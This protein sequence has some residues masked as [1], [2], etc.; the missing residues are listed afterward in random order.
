DPE[1]VTELFDAG[2]MAIEIP[3]AYGGAGRGLF[4]VVLAIEEIARVDPAVAVFVDVQ[5]ALVNSA[6]LR[7][8]SGDLKR[9]YLLRMAAGTVG[10]Y[11]I[12]EEE[13]GSDAFAMATVAQRD[14]QHHVL[15]GRKKWTTN[16]AE[17]GAFLVFARQ[18]DAT[19]DAGRITAFLVDRDTPGLGIGTRVDKLG[20]RASST[21][22]L[23]LDHVRV[24]AANV[25]GQSGL[26]ELLAVDTLTIGKIGI[27]AQ[28]VGLASGAL[29]AAVS[30]AQRRH[31]FGQPI[32]NFQGVQFP[33]AA[34]AAELSAARALL[35]DTVRLVD[36]GP[37]SRDLVT[38]AA[39]TKH[40]AAEVAE[41]TAAHA[42]ETLGGNGFTRD[43]PV[44]KFYRDA[45]VGKIYEGTTN[46][47]F[48][49]IAAALLR[50][51]DAGPREVGA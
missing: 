51:G 8:G 49:T 15:S 26:G 36:D 35:Y 20:I 45:K 3:E 4:D 24:P 21:C 22:D 25:I 40:I 43:H 14:G 18:Q 23:I 1:L 48:R 28:L 37:P 12:S 47:Q 2:L 42:V 16:A 9:R 33:L 6:I 27:A 5:N 13:A 41:R 39:M 10:A 38:A 46:M 32:A 17:A 19:A 11:A 30:Y 44:E 7:H 50:A 29:D 34:L 31:Q